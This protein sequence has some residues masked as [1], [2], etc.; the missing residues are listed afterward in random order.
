MSDESVALEQEIRR[1]I[2][3][4]NEEDAARLEVIRRALHE[5]LGQVKIKAR[6]VPRSRSWLA[7]WLGF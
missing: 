4:V 2:A 3:K 1:V 6:V 5:A 7:R